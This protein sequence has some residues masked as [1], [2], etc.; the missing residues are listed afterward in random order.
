[1]SPQEPRARVSLLPSK[2]DRTRRGTGMA[3][4]CAVVGGRGLPEG[5][6]GLDTHC[7][8]G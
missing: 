3:S 7:A 8:G 5:S 4:V 1:M 2:V 6:K